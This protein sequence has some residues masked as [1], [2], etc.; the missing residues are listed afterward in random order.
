MGNDRLQRSCDRVHYEINKYDN[1]EFRDL[2][3]F[4]KLQCNLVSVSLRYLYNSP[5][6]LS[7]KFKTFRIQVTRIPTIGFIHRNQ[8]FTIRIDLINL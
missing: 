8:Y 1:N 5:H 7:V 2:R 4:C 6:Y 3:T